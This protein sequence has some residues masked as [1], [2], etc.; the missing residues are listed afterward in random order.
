MGGAAHAKAWREGDLAAPRAHEVLDAIAQG[1]LWLNLR[2]VSGVNGRTWRAA[3]LDF[4]R[5]ER[6][7]AGFPA[8]QMAERHPDLLALGPGLLPCRPAGPASV[9]DRRRSASSS[10]PTAP[11]FIPARDL[12]DIALFDVEVD[13]PYA[14]WYDEHA[15][16]FDLAPGQ[17]L[18]WPLNAP[19]R[20][21]N[22]DGVNISM[23]VSFSSVE[24]RRGGLLHLA[25]GLLRHRFGVTPRSTRIEGAGFS[26]KRRAGEAAAGFRLGARAAGARRKVEFKLDA[27]AMAA[28]EWRSP[29]AQAPAQAGL[30]YHV[31][32]TDTYNARDWQPR[33]T[34]RPC[35]SAPTG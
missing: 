18:S 21:E 4:R 32:I 15:K 12:E 35:S 20:V 27:N 8:A 22:L 29:S 7:A 30:R 25:N 3:G 34:R 31:R 26:A 9:A 2:N 1:R 23:T 13:M 33:P 16:V 14:P 6:G 5:V 11:P 28:G 19:H 10:I 24:S 17:L